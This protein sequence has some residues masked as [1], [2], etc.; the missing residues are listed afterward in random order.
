MSNKEG[1]SGSG[2][3]NPER[4]R[5]ILDLYHHT[6]ESA[7][8]SILTKGLTSTDGEVYFSTVPHG[9]AGENRPV[10]LHFQVPESVATLN[11]FSTT[12]NGEK[13]ECW[14]IVKQDDLHP[15]QFKGIE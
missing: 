12:K 11:S 8:E 5:E 13:G 2:R 4:S 7:V 9:E 14:Y 1:L 15:D 10:A 3:K 6:K